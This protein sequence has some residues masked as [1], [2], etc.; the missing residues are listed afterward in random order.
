[1]DSV[2]FLTG[3]FDQAGRFVAEAYASTTTTAC[4]SSRS[5]STCTTPGATPTVGATSL[6]PSALTGP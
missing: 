4:T 3:Y 5:R 2:V 6:G 1:M